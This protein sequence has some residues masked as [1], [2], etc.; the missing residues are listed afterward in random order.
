[1]KKRSFS[2]NQH[3]FMIQILDRV[4][5]IQILDSI[6]RAVYDKPTANII[7]NGGKLKAILKAMC[8]SKMRSK[9]PLPPTPTQQST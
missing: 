7:L 4:D 9:T 6:I 3:G 5:W 1:M 8:S 2:Q